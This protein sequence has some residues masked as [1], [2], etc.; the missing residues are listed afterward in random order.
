MHSSTRAGERLWQQVHGDNL[1]PAAQW[2]AFHRL[3][4]AFK[5][6]VSEHRGAQELL[7]VAKAMSTHY[8]IGSGK[9]IFRG[10]AEA[11]QEKTRAVEAVGG[12]RPLVAFC[13]ASENLLANLKVYAAGFHV[14]IY[15]RQRGKGSQ[16][17][18][19]LTAAGRRLTSLDFVAF[20]A[21]WDDVMQNR[22]Q[23]FS[24]AS[25]SASMEPWVL[26]A[27]FDSLM[28]DLGEDLALLRALRRFVFVAN[29]M[30]H[31]LPQS[32]VAKFCAW[33]GG[34]AT[35]PAWLCASRPFFRCE[36]VGAS[37]AQAS[38]GVSAQWA[39]AFQAS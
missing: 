20:V 31:Y 13:R 21:A 12:T 15:R 2:D 5:S 16:T 8:G 25:Q 27:A 9:L 33:E 17:A 14:K 23:A 4:A 38:H 39:S 6:A 36:C 37:L 22:F 1:E 32:E 11:L 19:A 30:Q 29:L 34:E 35:F 3:N 10:V 26:Q 7:S 28:L 24:R 18:T